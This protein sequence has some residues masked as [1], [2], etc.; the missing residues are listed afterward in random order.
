VGRASRIEG[1]GAGSLSPLAGLIYV[2]D[3]VGAAD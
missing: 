3:W 1:S 2:H